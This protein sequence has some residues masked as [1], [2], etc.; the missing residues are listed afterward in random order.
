MIPHGILDRRYPIAT[1]T[2]DAVASCCQ[3]RKTKHMSRVCNENEATDH[4]TV[5]DMNMIE[6]NLVHLSINVM[7]ELSLVKC[8][9]KSFHFKSKFIVLT[10]HLYNLQNQAQFK[11]FLWKN[12]Q[13]LRY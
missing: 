4:G 8:C 13:H 2:I 6:L 3:L 7:N 5:D 12:H 1:R 9:V 11:S 10:H